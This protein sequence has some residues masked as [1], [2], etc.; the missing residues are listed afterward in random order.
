MKTAM[1]IIQNILKT[2]LNFIA[3]GKLNE[4]SNKIVQELRLEKVRVL[5]P[6]DLKGATFKLSEIPEDIL[7]KTI[8]EATQDDI[9]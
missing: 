9:K 8:S 1:D 4:V 3:E 5:E 6:S 2:E 7:S